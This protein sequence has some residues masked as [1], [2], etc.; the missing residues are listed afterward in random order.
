MTQDTQ[1]P[2]KSQ[3]LT[4]PMGLDPNRP[5]G[6]LETLA[7]HEWQMLLDKDDRTSPEEYPDM[8]LIDRAE[9][10]G[11]MTEAY[12][13]AKD[14]DAAAA[15]SEAPPPPQAI[16]ATPENIAAATEAARPIAEAYQRGYRAKEEELENALPPPAEGERTYSQAEV[17]SILR[18][19]YP[20]KSPDERAVLA[21]PPP[22]GETECGNC[23]GS[24]WCLQASLHGAAY[25]TC[26]VCNKSAERPLIR[27]RS[28]PPPQGLPE[29]VLERL[30]IAAEP[31]VLNRRYGVNANVMVSKADLRALLAAHPQ[32]G[33]G[34]PS[35]T[36][37]ADADAWVLVPR[38]P[39]EEM[40]RAGMIVSNV[41]PYRVTTWAANKWSDMLAASPTPPPAKDGWRP[42]ESGWLIE[43]WDSRRNALWWRLGNEDGGCWTPDSITALRFARA[44]DAQAYIDETGWT[45]A[46]PTEHRWTPPPQDTR[47]DGGA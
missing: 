19:A 8:A 42:I 39:T 13:L 3:G 43:R 28:V 40:Q 6:P 1:A 26:D 27:Y 45:E 24:G 34:A 20:T 31:D 7:D 21:P 29:G 16:E 10:G 25:E 33:G 46:T 44:E 14:Q 36:L 32:G 22:Q 9:F 37:P 17:D 41:G 2:D 23:D 12:L 30:T 18:A 47:S 5:K 15:R 11:V 4:R 38:E 35:T